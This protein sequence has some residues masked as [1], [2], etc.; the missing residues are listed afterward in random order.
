MCCVCT[1]L[2]VLICK[3]DIGFI[4]LFKIYLELAEGLG[5]DRGKKVLKKKFGK[6]VEFF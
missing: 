4:V 3:V 2:H 5:V 1:G 6:N